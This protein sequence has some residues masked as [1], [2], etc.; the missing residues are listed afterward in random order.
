MK[1]KVIPIVVGVLRTFPKGLEWGLEIK[2]R[3]KTIQISALLKS[4]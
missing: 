4:E 3:I 2:E 1:V